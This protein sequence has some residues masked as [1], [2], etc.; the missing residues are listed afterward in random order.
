VSILESALDLASRGIPVFPLNASRKPACDH[1]HLDASTDPAA[2]RRLFATPLA[3]AIG[4]ATGERAGFDVLDVDPRN[5]GGAWL[6]ENEPRLPMTRRHHTPRG[7]VH[8]LLAHAPGMRCSTGQIALGVDIKADGGYAT[9]HP[10]N[11]LHAEGE[12]WAPWPDWLLVAALRSRHSP[13]RA[14]AAPEERAPPSAAALVEVLHALPNP[15]GTTRED[16][17]GLNLAVQGCIRALE[18]LDRIEGGAE[19]IRDAAAGW[20]ARWDS[21]RAAGVETEL[22]RWDSDWSTRTADLTGWP[23]VLGLAA[24]F[25]VDVSG[26]RLAAAAAEFAELPPVEPAP[27]AAPRVLSDYEPEPAPQ[28]NDPNWKNNLKPKSNGKIEGNLNNVDKVLRSAPAWSGVFRLNTFANQIEIAR[29]PPFAAE[30]PREIKDV[31]FTATAVWFQREDIPV[32]PDTCAQAISLVAQGDH[33][34]PVVDYL[35]G[36]TPDGI[37][38]IDTWLVDYLGAMDTPLNRAVGAKFLISAVARA[39]FPGCQVDSMLVLEGRQGLK[40]STVLRDLFGSR[41]F[42]DH[43]P[44]LGHKDAMSQLQGVWLVEHAEMATLGL[45]EA[46]RAKEFISRRV[47]RF[48]PSYGRVNA[49][50]PRQCVFAATV[51]PGGKGYLKDETGARRFWPVSC[52]VGWPDTRQA[53]VSALLAARDSLW[54]EAAARYRAGES[55]WLD[56]A[57]LET[58]QASA[59]ESRYD[60]DI[61]TDPV[62]AFVAGRA[63]V[64]SGA[65]LGQLG[66]LTANQDKRAQIRLGGILRSLGW[67]TGTHRVSG[68]VFR[69][70]FAPAGAEITRE[71]ALVGARPADEFDATPPDGEEISRLLN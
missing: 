59:A 70:Y 61:W 18:A 38:R 37:P 16:Y 28:A 32:K 9:W 44:D 50:F 23:H 13:A 67:A 14:P 20:C 41:W 24:R 29:K 65:V 55:W 1:G 69:G 22:A 6:A 51:N 12:G 68:H 57:E 19:A 49:N 2:V 63:F 71:I 66:M 31:D 56:R 40:K 5:G 26:H 58:A 54:A 48:R 33:F 36:L 46:N 4:V 17:T 34:S 15:A 27:V 25:G 64:Q 52:G 62:S 35:S 11:G 3:W 47:D 42:T 45:A 7:G 10:A 39:M 30:W 60:A 8:F 21:D 43:I 53:N